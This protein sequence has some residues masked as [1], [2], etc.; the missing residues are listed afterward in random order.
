[1]YKEERSIGLLGDIL[2][3]DHLGPDSDEILSLLNKADVVLGNLETTLATK[4][5]PPVK[6]FNLKAPHSVVEDFRKMNVKALSLAN[7]HTMD[8]GFEGLFETMKVLDE[9]NIAHV[10]AG[11][12]LTEA[13][14]PTTLRLG[15]QTIAFLACCTHV[16]P[17][18]LVAGS[19]RPGMVPLRNN[20]QIGITMRRGQNHIAP[21]RYPAIITKA[22]EADLKTLSMAVENVKK[23]ADFVVVSIH[24]GLSFQPM[25]LDYQTEAAH[26]LIDH[27]ADII[28]GHGPHVLHGIEVYKKRYIFYSLGHFVRHLSQPDRAERLA[29][30][31]DTHPLKRA[32]ADPVRFRQNEAAIAMMVL[33]G[34]E[35]RRVEMV[36]VALDKN[37]NPQVC[38]NE[39]AMSILNY[40]AVHSRDL[41]TYITIKNNKGIIEA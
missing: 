38:D 3:Y 25:V 4:G 35:I 5:N 31:P 30:L 18:L 24:W 36:P 37:M 17:S 6:L 39:S 2:I 1:M 13:L 28:M 7:N 32:L 34:P 16:T 15:E 9:H 23:E 40:L 8:F 19:D 12:N 11:R 29:K 41:G 27:G 14:K 20:V 22:D 33:S 21:P 26:T 10:G